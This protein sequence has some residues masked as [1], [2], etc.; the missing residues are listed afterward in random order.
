M[1][2]GSGLRGLNLGPPARALVAVRSRFPIRLTRAFALSVAVSSAW[3]A[4][5]VHAQAARQPHITAELVSELDA[6]TPGAKWL[7]ALRL[8]S[9]PLWHT[10]WKNAGDAGSPPSLDWALPPGFRATPIRWPIPH[11]IAEP[12]LAVYGYEGEALFLTEVEA[13]GDLRPGQVVTLR[14]HAS[15]VVCRVDCVAGEADLARRVAVSALVG[16]A[17]RRWSGPL[18]AAYAGLPRRS[19]EWRVSATPAA[20]GY[21]MR[22]VPPPGWT[23]PIDGVLFFPDSGAVIEHAAAQSLAHDGAAYT[24]ALT[25]SPYA[26][27]KAA[28]LTGLLVSRSGWDPAGT[29]KAIEVDAPIGAGAAAGAVP[30]GSLTL[31]LALGLAFVGGILLNLM[32]CVFPVVS[33]KVL[34]FA[35]LAGVGRRGLWLHGIATGAGVL[36]T[37]WALSGVLLGLRHAGHALGWGFQLQSPTFVTA[38]ALLLFVLGLNLLGVFEIGTS[39]TRLSAA[40]GHASRL[41]ESFGTGVLATVVATPCTA[42]FMGVAVGYGLTRPAWQALLVFTVLGLGMAAPYALLAA[43]PRLLERL[44]RPG[45]W[46]VTFR[47]AVAFPLLATAAWLIWVLAQQTDADAVLRVLIALTLLAIAAWILGRWNPLA[48]SWRARVISRSVAAAFALGAVA[49]AVPRAPAAG[50]GAPPSAAVS[51][52]PYTARRLAELRRAGR[53]VFV[54]FTAAWCLTCKVNERVALGS[55]TVQE[56]L[57]QLDV[58]TLRADWTTG[59]PEITQALAAFGRNSVPLYVLYHGDPGLPPTVL[60]TLLTPSIVLDALDGAAAGGSSL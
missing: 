31:W 38:M 35:N 13:P 2:A 34:S 11:R 55:R 50:R 49:L 58:A 45:P 59:D 1:D 9:D 29:V 8:V 39:L 32:P 57:R 24:L 37:F 44:P 36:A 16:T 20:T 7:M 10:Y 25:T 4:G 12:P 56:R 60:P 53:L 15:W 30:A 5:P 21:T 17:D 33:L 48:I 41:A 28:R 27:R 6:I 19:P 51:W 14:A 26:T 42:P 18:R 46:M 22:I 40:P 43:S 3:A 54:D 52:E 23:R 47:Q